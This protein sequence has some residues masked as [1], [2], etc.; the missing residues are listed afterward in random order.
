MDAVDTRKGMK[1]K[2]KRDM[3]AGSNKREIERVIGKIRMYKPMSD[4]NKRKIESSL[5]SYAAVVTPGAENEIP[6]ACDLFEAGLCKHPKC[7]STALYREKGTSGSR[8]YCAKHARI[9]FGEGNFEKSMSPC[10]VADCP[11]NAM[12]K[13]AGI[14]RIFTHCCDHRGQIPGKVEKRRTICQYPKCLT[15]CSYELDGGLWYCAKHRDMILRESRGKLAVTDEVGIPCTHCTGPVR[16]RALH[17]LWDDFEK[18]RRA[19]THCLHCAKR[20]GGDWRHAYGTYCRGRKCRKRATYGIQGT[21]SIKDGLYA[22]K[23]WCVD[24]A[25]DALKNLEKEKKIGVSNMKV[26][27]QNCRCLGTCCKKGIV[28]LLKGGRT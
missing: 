18:G 6:A 10:V 23:Y 28:R 27:D 13:L 25:R 3:V 16:N 22:Y 11:N 8:C 7:N 12:L 20:E 9:K 4:F 15:Q 14:G 21:Q 2:D 17:L 1:S 5:C 19:P 24:C 26:V